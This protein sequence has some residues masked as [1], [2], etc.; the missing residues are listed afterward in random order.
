MKYG[1]IA[2]EIVGDACSSKT[3]KA[4]VQLCCSVIDL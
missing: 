1:N 3:G 2:F 4:A